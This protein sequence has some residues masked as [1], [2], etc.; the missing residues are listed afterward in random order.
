MSG[1][2]LRGATLVTVAY[3]INDIGWGGKADDEHRQKY[4]DSIRGIIEACRDRKVRVFICSAAITGGDHG[5]EDY[6]QRMCDE[7]MAISRSLGQG[8]IDVQRS[9]HVILQHIR[10]WNQDHKDAHETMHTAD[11][12]HLND[13]GQLAMAFAILKGLGAERRTSPRRRSARRMRAW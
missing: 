12:I 2:C 9:M 7:G 11:T 3:G 1:T 6:L 5:E 10:K 8:S 4:L 13:L